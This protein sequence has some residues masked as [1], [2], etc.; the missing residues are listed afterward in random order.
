MNLKFEF[1]L[2]KFFKS[3]F[4]LF[5]I[6]GIFGAFTIYLKGFYNSEYPSLLIEY[7]IVS[8]FLISILISLV[9]IRNSFENISFENISFNLN[10]F[11]N[12][13]NLLDALF[14]VGKGNIKRGLFLMPFIAFLFVLISIILTTFSDTLPAIL[15]IGIKIVAVILFFNLFQYLLNAK[16]NWNIVAKY[17]V[18]TETIALILYLIVHSYASI[19]FKSFS[20]LLETLLL[21]MICFPIGTLF[22]ILLGAIL[23]KLGIMK[24]LREEQKNKDKK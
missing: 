13:M 22:G 7:G 9:I 14:F 10:S 4:Q 20:E 3:N 18:I 15:S 5:V 17:L 19:L 8:S 6:M 16:K 24:K 1:E 21:L 11:E 2:S 12:I 23:D